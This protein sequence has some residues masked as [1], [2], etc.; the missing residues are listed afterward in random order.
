MSWLF[1]VLG[2]VRVERDD[3]TL[4]LESQRAKAVL[5]ALVLDL[6]RPVSVDRLI[7]TVWGESPPGRAQPTLQVHVSNLRRSLGDGA[8]LLTTEPPG[9]RLRIEPEQSD[10]GRFDALGVAAR[11]HR[12]GGRL[13]D[14]AAALESALALW[15]GSPLAD[16]PSTPVLEESRNWLE[17][18][19]L[20]AVE[21]H[22]ELR[23]HLGRHREAVPDL[24]RLVQRY[25][26][27]ETLW[28]LLIRGHYAAG[29]SSDA[30]NAYRRARRT[31]IDELG[32]EPGE[33]LRALEAAVL[34]RE[35]LP[36]LDAGAAPAR[37]AAFEPAAT[38]QAPGP[39]G[40]YLVRA[41]GGKIPI[42]ETVTIGRHPDC[43]ITLSDP[44]VSR[45]HAEIRPVMGG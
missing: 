24:E 22:Q 38:Q 20:A 13:A 7:E 35:P 2:P 39:R 9:Y 1:R 17:S 15:T 42:D 26:L 14:A 29:S 10:L 30:L 5:A 32:V 28:E 3:V 25:P 8:E 6:G 34:A 41:D 23:L 18:R 31:M 45:R 37:P 4:P 19:Y 16:L 33:R 40:G 21:E 44:A 27:R 12:A 36:D 43:T 11:G